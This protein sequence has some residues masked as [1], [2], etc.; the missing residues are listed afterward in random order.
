MKILAALD[1]SDAAFNAM[2]SACRIAL[3]TG[4]YITAFY[5]N[6]GVQYSPEETGWTSIRERIARELETSGHEV[7]HKAYEIGKDFGVPVEG[8]ISDGIPAPQILAHVNAHGIIKLIA[9]GHSSKGK[10][11][12]EFVESTTK[13]VA[14]RAATPV[15]VTSSEIEIRSILIA[16]GNSAAAG[17][18]AA[19]GGQLAKSLGAELNVVAYIPDAEA[20]ISEYRLIADVPNIEKHIEASEK[21]LKEM[22]ERAL[23]ATTAVLD[24]VG[25]RASTL[26]KKGQADDLI[27]EAQR[28]DVLVLGLRGNPA[29]TKFSRIANRLLDSPSLNTVFVQ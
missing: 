28:Y 19:F 5:V 27:L 16:V 14:A 9:M 8:V 12:Q 26:I 18:V 11:A 1:G 7:I 24:S 15:F 13:G 10:G 4:F 6:K 22:L 3:K 29:H 20:M 23:A 21:E 17:N 2:K 25:V